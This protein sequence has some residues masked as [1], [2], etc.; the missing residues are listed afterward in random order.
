MPDS[1]PF[2]AN[3]CRN[4]PTTSKRIADGGG[5]ARP[6]FWSAVGFGRTSL[7]STDALPLPP[8]ALG[9]FPSAYQAAELLTGE[10]C[11]P[12]IARVPACSAPC[13]PATSTSTSSDRGRSTVFDRK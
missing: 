8:C 9:R 2:R 10:I 4:C 13:A 3:P 5:L 1:P 6:V 7:P 11:Y 12:V